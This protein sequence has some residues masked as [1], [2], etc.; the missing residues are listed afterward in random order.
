MARPA[1]LNAEWFT[2]SASLRNDRRVKA[3]RTATGAAG[4]GIFH[5]LLEAL[6]DADYTMLPVDE[7]ELELLAGDFG[8]SVTEIDSLL[9]IGK[10]VGYF[11]V[12]D[13]NMLTCPE[14][15][16]W[17]EMH[18]EKRNRS[19]NRGSGDKPSQ[20]DAETGVPVT[21]IPHNTLHNT[22]VQDITDERTDVPAPEPAVEEVEEVV[23]EELPTEGPVAQAPHT[24]G[25]RSDE[26]PPIQF[27]AFR[28]SKCATLE[29]LQALAASLKLADVNVEYY[30]DKISSKASLEDNRTP[31]AWES[32]ATRFLVNDAKRNNLITNTIAVTPQHNPQAYAVT[33]STTRQQ[34]GQKPGGNAGQLARAI[35][36]RRAG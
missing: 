27:M 6:T 15:N 5:M 7:I 4:Y 13:A 14:L 17:L 26:R 25:A 33:G 24:R 12:D 36:E 10:K 16:R 8:V 34:P 31:E 11:L 20:P 23:A 35:A 21:E 32:Y 9:Q 3:I 28:Q 30:L 22:T 18:F 2:H 29:G 1:K 19:R